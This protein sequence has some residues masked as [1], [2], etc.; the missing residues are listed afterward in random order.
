MV[1]V[2]ITVCKEEVIEIPDEVYQGLQLC[3]RSEEE[4]NKWLAAGKAVEQ[5]VGLPFAYEGTGLREIATLDGEIL[6]QA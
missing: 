4:H 5:I 6:S 1:K 3:P 2:K